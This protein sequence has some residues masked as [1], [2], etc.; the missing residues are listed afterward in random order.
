MSAP[1]PTLPPR[2]ARSQAGSNAAKQEIPQI[3]PRPQ[4]HERVE[5]PVREAFTRSP[6]N[7]PPVSLNNGHFYNH[8]KNLSASDLPQRP[9][10]VNLPSIGQEGNEYASFDTSSVE[11]KKPRSPEQTRNIAPDLP[12]HAPKASVP[13]STATTRIATVTRTDSSQAAAAGVGKARHDDDKEPESR[14]LSMRASF[15]RS[16]QSLHTG[17]TPRPGSVHEP[18]HDEH[19]IP[20]IGMQV[21][22]YPNAGD[23]QAP[24]P[25]PYA[26]THSAGIGF[27]NDG[28]QTAPRHHGR[29]RS[30]R[31]EFGPPGSYGL[32]GHGLH[33]HVEPKDKF[34]KAWYQRHPEELDK[35]VHRRYD[36]GHPL[37]EWALSSE[38]LNKLIHANDGGPG[39]GACYRTFEGSRNVAN[40][41]LGTSPDMIGTPTEQIGYRA[42]EQYQSRLAS[43]KSTPAP[44]GTLR[45]RPSSS[46]NHH[47]ESPLRKESF[48]ANERR[49]EH[50]EALHSDE[51]EEAGTIHVDPPSRRGSK[52]GGGGYDPP[53]ENLGPHGGNTSEEGG[54]IN[55]RG[56]GVPI[57]ASDEVMK[58]PGSA[59]L[60]PAVD[61]EQEKRGEEYYAGVDSEHPP[62]YQS[63]RSGNLSHSRPTSRPNSMHGEPLARL[64]SHDRY[65][66]SGAGTPLEEIEEYEPLFPDDDDK[67]QEPKGAVE[68]LKRPDLARHHFPSQD[69]W[70]DTPNSLQYT[71]TVDAEQ[72]PEEKDGTASMDS[73]RV[74]E[75][76]EKELAR[77]EGNDPSDRAHFLPKETEQ[78]ADPRYKPGVLQDIPSRHDMRHRFPSRDIWEDTPDSMR[79]ETTVSEPQDE[80][81]TSPSDAQTKSDLEAKDEAVATGTQLPPMPA[82]PTGAKALSPTDRKAP[83][84]PDRPKPQIPAR[85]ANRD[86]AEGAA[87]SK[88]TSAGST[89]SDGTSSTVT[90]PPLNKAKP[91]VPSRPAG[92][93]FAALKAGFMNDLNSR[94]QLGPQAPVPKAPE[95]E[96]TPAEE[97]V[98][99]ADARKGR[100]KGP[101]RRKPAASSSGADETS[102]AMSLS[103]ATTRTLF[104]IG[105]NDEL[106]VPTH[107]SGSSDAVIEANVSTLPAVAQ[108]EKTTLSGMTAHA[109]G[110]TGDTPEPKLSPGTI[111]RQQLLQ[112]GLEAALSGTDR[113]AEQMEQAN[114]AEP[115]Q[116]E[117]Q[118]HSNMTSSG[119]QT[120]QLDMEITSP[121][122]EQE[123][124]TTI[125]GG[126]AP[127]EGNVVIKGNGEQ[128]V[129]GIDQNT[130]RKIGMTGHG[131]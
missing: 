108:D 19:G 110:F 88:V 90:S 119:V 21:P 28:T 4:R 67:V 103:F 3:P 93:K 130:P 31:H 106:V 101:A 102:P 95:P 92:S 20:V 121:K 83:V 39:F 84:V 40:V 109:I 82:R 89:G 63:G 53:V 64:K 52:Y 25:S 56:H 73:S 128:E 118:E 6:L 91:A 85:P 61:P 114:A 33:G 99:L 58:R 122:G 41:K 47:M 48:A 107:E 45:G 12:M 59:Y 15:N 37:P 127:Q 49:G 76:P 34:E 97:Q 1:V 36:P 104:H 131:M 43:A 81:I 69:I 26:Q 32:H 2:P 71:T 123:K 24:S 51:E 16:N 79:L 77:Q 35:E 57:L 14:S 124:I 115:E 96:E 129:S 105:E 13:Q 70:E 72:Q 113:S 87:L 75:P 9:P 98:P 66:A 68:K 117:P 126:A 125:L 29:R 42:S 111:E 44:L 11:E 78:Y 80:E 7:E 120:G 74:F 23:V 86:G 65:D 17:S 112:P 22:M 60:H 18:E 100:V 116:Q 94:L 62:S 8:H 5:S 30:S 54:W 50:D 10:S 46:S 27:F 38:D 55:E